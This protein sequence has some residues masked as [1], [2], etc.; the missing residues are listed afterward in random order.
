MGPETGVV[1]GELP[2]V[3]LQA[4]ERRLRVAMVTSLRPQCGIAEYSRLLVEELTSRVE[5]AWIT[6]PNGFAP[7]MNQADV[8]HIQHQYFLF[9]GVAPWK[10]T[11]CALADQITAPTVMTVHEFVPPSGNLARRLAIAST[12]RAQFGHPAVRLFIVHTEADRNHLVA[13]GVQPQRIWVLPHPVPKSP[14]LPSVAE[15]RARFGLGD[16]FVLTIFGFVARRKGHLIA[17][18]ALSHLPGNVRLL[19]A[20]GRHPDDRTDYMNQVQAAIG[21]AKLHDRVTITGYLDAVD[22]GHAMAA[23]DL[24][25]APFTAGSGSG[26]LAFAFACGKPVLASAIPP[27]VEMERRLPGCLALVPPNDAQELAAAVLRLQRDRRALARL[28]E[29]A[30]RYAAQ[31]SYG[32]FAEQTI[33]LYRNVLAEPRR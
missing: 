20:G 25:L 21:A 19:I 22:V 13:A 9:G 16:A 27:N 15:A 18:Q 24:V 32:W 8:I 28:A 11:F 29:D 7:V 26:S 14:C 17:I 23:T 2:S 33:R 30:T 4:S 31:Y 3:S 12:N 10:N 1:E 5:V 6:P